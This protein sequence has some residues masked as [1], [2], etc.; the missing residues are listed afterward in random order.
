MKHILM[1]I[2]ERF[3]MITG[4]LLEKEVTFYFK[5]SFEIKQLTANLKLL[6]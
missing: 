6:E 4:T 2:H 5:N 1:M 3:L